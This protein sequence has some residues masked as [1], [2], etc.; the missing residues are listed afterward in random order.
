MYSVLAGLAYVARV[1]GVLVDEWNFVF[2]I[3]ETQSA[4]KGI[5]YMRCGVC[6]AVLRSPDVV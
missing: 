5:P 4:A 1:Y 6:V 3:V 2:T